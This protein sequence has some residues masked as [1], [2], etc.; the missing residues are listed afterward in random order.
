MFRH[1]KQSSYLC[2]YDWEHIKK[3][4]YRQKAMIMGL[5]KN[6]FSLLDVNCK[7]ILPFFKVTIS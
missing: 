2:F 4:S 6:H 5:N 7:L 1:K 3:P